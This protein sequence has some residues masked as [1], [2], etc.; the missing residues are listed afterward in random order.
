MSLTSPLSP[1]HSF[2]PGPPVI[3]IHSLA[4]LFIPRQFALTA[5]SAR[6]A[7]PA[8]GPC[9]TC[10]LAR[11]ILC[12]LRPC[13]TCLLARS[14]LLLSSAYVSSSATPFLPIPTTL[15]TLCLCYLH[16]LHDLHCNLV[17]RAAVRGLILTTCRARAAVRGLVQPHAALERR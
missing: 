13:P 6:V 2:V 11:S 9:P 5:R 7:P 8:A 15:L 1:A 3:N 17:L 14:M 4:W 16:D 10:L 12:F